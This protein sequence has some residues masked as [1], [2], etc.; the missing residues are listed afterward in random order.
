METSQRRLA[1]ILSADAVAYSRLM[2][3]DEPGTV[4]ALREHHDGMRRR[5]E[6]QRGRV[7]DSPGD[8][9][10][11]GLPSIVEAVQCAVEIQRDVETRNESQPETRRMCFRIG[12]HLGDVIVEGERI[13]GDGVNVAARLEGLAEPGGVCLSGEAFDQVKELFERGSDTLFAGGFFPPA[14]AVPVPGGWRV[15]ARTAF[16]SGCHRAHWFALPIVEVDDESSKF[17]PHTE[18][19][20]P[21]VAFVPREEVSILDT[22]HT[23]GMRGTFSADVQVDDAVGPAR[24]IAQREARDRAGAGL[25]RAALWNLPLALGAR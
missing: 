20:P 5:I 3:E 2:A 7:V 1:A 6:A 10:L 12:V 24:R 18:D 17:D 4:R 22:W 8:N 21:L 23:S 9:L 25:R 15:T 11:A 16:N 19:P 14:P 13:Y